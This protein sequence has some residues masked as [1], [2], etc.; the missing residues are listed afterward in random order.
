MNSTDEQKIEEIYN[1]GIT[2]WLNANEVGNY[3]LVNYPRG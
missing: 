3:S 2:Y 1:K